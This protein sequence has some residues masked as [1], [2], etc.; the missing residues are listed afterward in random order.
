MANSD[1]DNVSVLLGNG[2]GT[3]ASDVL[4]GVGT[5]PRSVVMA[6]MDDDGHLDVVVSNNVGDNISIAIG[7]GAGWS[8]WQSLSRTETV[9]VR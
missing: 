7:N 1:G 8:K 4:Y 5:T 6:D 3:F 9:S 2:D